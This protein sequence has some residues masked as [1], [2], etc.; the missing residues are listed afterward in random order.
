[1]LGPALFILSQN[2]TPVEH[3]SLFKA[4][5]SHSKCIGPHSWASQDHIEK[6]VQAGGFPTL[7]GQHDTNTRWKDC[8]LGKPQRREPISR[9][10]LAQGYLALGEFP[11]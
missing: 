9:Q 1:L 4:Y 10:T 11:E 6:R 3:H 5:L 8:K 7:D 2:A